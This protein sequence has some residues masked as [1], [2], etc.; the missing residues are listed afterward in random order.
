MKERFKV[1][2][3]GS[4]HWFLGNQINRYY[5]GFCTMDQIRFTKTILNKFTLPNRCSMGT[6][7]F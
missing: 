1:E 5:D 4:A 6:T 2:D 7:H 3:N